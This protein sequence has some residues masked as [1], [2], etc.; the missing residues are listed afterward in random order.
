MRL[1]EF[2]S[3]QD[4]LALWKLI[5]DTVWSRLS[6]Q[7]QSTPLP[8]QARPTPRPQAKPAP[9][10]KSISKP[11]KLKARKVKPSS[12]TAKASRQTGRF[13]AN[14]AKPTAQQMNPA[15][16]TRGIAAMN[17]PS[18]SPSIDAP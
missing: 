3:A 14:P 13:K 16:A 5:S 2:A 6:K 1:A 17:A 9:Q 10:R 4:Q 11:N 8:A 18:K 7:S 15:M 12:T